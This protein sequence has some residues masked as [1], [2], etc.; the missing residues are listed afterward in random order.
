MPWLYHKYVGHDL[1]RDAFMMNMPENRNLA[2][3]FYTEW[4][5]QIF[6]TMHQMG[7]KGPRFFV[8]PNY[9]PIDPNYDPLIWR[10]AALLGQAMALDLEQHDHSGVISNAMYDYYW[11]GY[12]DSAPLGHNTVCLLT[13]AASVRLANPIDIKAS[14]LTG[15]SRGFPDHSPQINFPNPWPGGTWR[16]RDIVE[17]DLVAARGLIG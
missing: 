15:S 9:E 1:N 16:L 17:Y 4:H 2:R 7:I 13:E 8:P 14:E 11:P 5:P 12:E 10:E 3:F 6:L